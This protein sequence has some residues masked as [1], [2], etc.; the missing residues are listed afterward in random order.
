MK[1]AEDA[2]QRLDKF[3]DKDVS[4][5]SAEGKKEHVE[6][7]ARL[8][9]RVKDREAALANL[10]NLHGVKMVGIQVPSAIK[11]ALSAVE[12]A[13]GAVEGASREVVKDPRAGEGA[14]REVEEASRAGEGA[15]REVEGASR[16]GEGASRAV[17]GAS[18]A[19]EGAPRAVEGAS[20]AVGGASRAVEGASRAVGGASRAVEGASRAVEEARDAVRDAQ[21][22]AKKDKERFLDW[23]A[24]HNNVWS[25]KDQRNH[26][27]L[28][29]TMEA[30]DLQVGKRESALKDMLAVRRVQEV[31][32]NSPDETMLTDFWNNLPNAIEENKV[33][34]FTDI[35]PFFPRKMKEMKSLFIR[36]SYV[37]MFDLF[38]DM[39]FSQTEERESGI[40][41]TGNPGVGKSVFLF[42]ALWRISRM[43]EGV[44]TVV[45][46]RAKDEGDIYVFEEDGCWIASDISQ[47]RRLFSLSTT[48]YLTDTPKKPPGDHEAITFLVASP[49]REHYKEFLKYGQTTTLRYLPVWS[50][51]ELYLASGLYDM[52]KEKVEE[53]YNLIGGIARFV[54]EKSKVNLKEEIGIALKKFEMKHF[55]FLQGVDDVSKMNQSILHFDVDEKFESESMRFCSDYAAQKAVEKFWEGKRY[56]LFVFLKCSEADSSTAALRGQLFEQVAHKMLAAGGKFLCRSLEE[57]GSLEDEMELT[58]RETDRYHELTA[59]TEDKYWKP[60]SSNCPCIDSLIP[61][62]YLFQMTISDQHPINKPKMVE[63][64]SKSGIKSLYFVVPRSKFDN[65]RKQR[66]DEKG[67]KGSA[68]VAVAE[69][70][71][72]PPKKKHKQMGEKKKTMDFDQYVVAIDYEI[73]TS[74]TLCSK[75]RKCIAVSDTGD[76]TSSRTS[77]DK[78]AE[79]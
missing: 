46:H 24:Q 34:T 72:E 50:L 1:A 5:L 54:L 32:N 77:L 49:E 11:K 70:D 2:R 10:L 12:G 43:K 59:C 74:S 39:N 19:V 68:D 14:S 38:M 3:T 20:R 79:K 26:D 65:F 52:K 44:G 16:A 71:A 29:G 37:R 23:M 25:A 60:W 58:P 56:E 53:R 57:E 4:S 28:K 22:E 47:V 40:A 69:G 62:K 61:N 8:D 73:P 7:K 6:N 9:Q 67:G 64:L 31:D 35:P 63:V 45:L 30:S 48:W 21:S 76:R 55:K 15:S 42:Y 17:E 51:D 13:P 18:S 36:E 27:H 33:L 41:I 78:E 66:L 75:C